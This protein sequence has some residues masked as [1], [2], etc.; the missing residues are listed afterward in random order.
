MKQIILRCFLTY[1]YLIIR[2]ILTYIPLGIF[3]FCI[4]KNFELNL[5]KNRRLVFSFTL[6]IEYF[7]LSGYRIF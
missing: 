7:N 5:I 6:G 2:C 3:F 4:F 1:N